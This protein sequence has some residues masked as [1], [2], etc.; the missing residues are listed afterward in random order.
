[1]SIG[2][3]VTLLNFVIS[4]IP[5]YWISIYRL[6]VHVRHTIDKLRKHFLWYGGNIVRKKI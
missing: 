6:P 1:M 2:G 4:S 5:L 3:G